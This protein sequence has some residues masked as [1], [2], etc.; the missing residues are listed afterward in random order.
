MQSVE[1]AALSSCVSASAS[2][3]PST[4]YC[5]LCCAVQ[6]SKSNT[7][8]ACR[9]SSANWRRCAP[10]SRYACFASTCCFCCSANPHYC[11]ALYISRRIRASTGLEAACS[12]AVASLLALLAPHSTSLNV[13]APSRVMY[14]YSTVQYI[15]LSN[16]KS[17]ICIFR[18]DS[19]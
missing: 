8:H 6:S 3:F 5:L 9:S 18:V 19:Q 13:S 7:R 16:C 1:R 11:T 17:K 14:M 15:R 10:R 12:S 4:V 2:V